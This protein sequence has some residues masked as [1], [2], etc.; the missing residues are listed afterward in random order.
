[1]IMA[2]NL[3]LEQEFRLA[4]KYNQR[5]KEIDNSKSKKLLIAT[6][7]QMMLQDNLIKFFARNQNLNL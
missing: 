4:V 5:I 7:K 6:L 1:M 3:T 2:N